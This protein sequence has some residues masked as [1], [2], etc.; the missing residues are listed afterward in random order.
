MEQVPLSL[1]LQLKQ[2]ERADLAAVSRAAIEFARVIEALA[3][4]VYPESVI[5]IEA[6]SAT[7][8]SFGWNTV[9]KFYE[10][11]KAGILAGAAKNPKKAWLAAFV[12]LRILNNAIDWSQDK[13]MDWLVS[14]DA[15]P[16]TRSL[17]EE[18]RA[19][20]ARDIVTELRKGTAEAETERMF[21]ELRRDPAIEG[22]GVTTIP[23]KRPAM[24]VNKADF[25]RDREDS[26]QAETERTV[27]R[28][29]QTT[30]VSPVLMM[31]E[32]R[33]KF[34][35]ATGEFGAPIRD[36]DF[37]AK[38]LGGDLDIRLRAGLVME[39]DLETKERLEDGVW[40][41][42]S[43]TVTKVHG[44]RNAPEQQDLLA[45]SVEIEPDEKE[46]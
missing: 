32:R 1:Y 44:W 7:D 38:I 8:A 22:A 15:P 31:G 11:V 26:L 37:L 29:I 27:S 34:R 25:L 35:S 3:F 12:A 19:D 13:V 10:D 2:G 18:E 9:V 4:E 16:E 28:R 46:D 14:E 17:T 21:R 42:E 40:V 36:Q 6:V 43:R 33:W 30:L 39:I 24:I 23:G 5:R 20:L 45:G 41:I